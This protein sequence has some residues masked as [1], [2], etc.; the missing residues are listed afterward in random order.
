MNPAWSIQVG[1]KSDD[2]CPSERQE[3][4]RHRKGERHVK[5]EAERDWSNAAE[6]A[7]RPWSHQE[8]KSK[9]GFSSGALGQ[10]TP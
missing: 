10:L 2:R 9:E 5:M 4:I 8:P 7:E 1:D 6:V 3:R